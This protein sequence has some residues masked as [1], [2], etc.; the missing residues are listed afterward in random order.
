MA[1]N[2]IAT[3][4]REVALSALHESAEFKQIAE[5]AGSFSPIF[6]IRTR[7][8]KPPERLVIIIQSR[9]EY[10]RDRGA[11]GNNCV[12]GY[13]HI[14][15][16]AIEPHEKAAR[17]GGTPRLDQ[18]AD[19]CKIAITFLLFRIYVGIRWQKYSNGTQQCGQLHPAR[20]RQKSAL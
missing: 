1:A 3:F 5:L 16:Q 19:R 8:G 14:K 12:N 2:N 15:K 7:A 18:R 6:A 17:E 13:Y 9:N 10:K 4:G 11:D 20:G